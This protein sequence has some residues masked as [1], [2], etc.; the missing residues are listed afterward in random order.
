MLSRLTP[1]L[2]AGRERLIE[3]IQPLQFSLMSGI[4]L[5]EYLG[6]ILLELAELLG[7]DHQR[8]QLAD[9]V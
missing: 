6:G 4:G 3:W 8:C 7:K 9:V 5:F 2:A 1:L